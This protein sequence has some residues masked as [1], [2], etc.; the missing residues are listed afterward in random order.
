MIFLIVCACRHVSSLRTREFYHLNHLRMGSKKLYE[1]IYL[2]LQRKDKMRY[3]TESLR[4]D[5]TYT[6]VNVHKCINILVSIYCF[7]NN[8]VCYLKVGLL[9]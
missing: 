2:E 6:A 1:R 9:F 7:N 8:T 3:L 5:N 4:L